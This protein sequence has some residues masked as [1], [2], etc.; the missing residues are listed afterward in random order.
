M[1]AGD[2]DI[3]NPR[4]GLSAKSVKELVKGLNDLGYNG[5]GIIDTYA[6]SGDYSALRDVVDEAAR[7]EGFMDDLT[8]GFFLKN[9]STIYEGELQGKKYIDALMKEW[10]FKVE[11]Q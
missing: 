6:V 3:P 2:F 8:Y 1:E 11:A 9:E 7:R 5:E 4:Y 10:T